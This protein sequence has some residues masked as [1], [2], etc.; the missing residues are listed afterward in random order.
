[1]GVVCAAGVPLGFFF[2]WKGV[3]GALSCSARRGG[4]T[5]C[6]IAPMHGTRDWTVSLFATA[7]RAA[8]GFTK[9]GVLL[10]TCQAVDHCLEKLLCWLGLYVQSVYGCS[11]PGTAMCVSCQGG[12]FKPTQP[13]VRQVGRE[14][15]DLDS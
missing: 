1:M 4:N 3:I 10:A 2:L 11:I 8:Q 12:A 13:L 7:C 5:T 14:D 9:H 15:L 6:V